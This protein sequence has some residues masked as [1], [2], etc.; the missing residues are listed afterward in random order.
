MMPEQ[1]N[2]NANMVLSGSEFQIL[3]VA[4]RKVLLT[5]ADSLKDDTRWLVRLKCKI[6]SQ[7]YGTLFTSPHN[8]TNTA[9]I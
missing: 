7:Q 1:I 8:C 4:T 6:F 9:C 3:V 5:I 2:R